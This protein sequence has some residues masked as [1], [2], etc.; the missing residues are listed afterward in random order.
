ML[1]LRLNIT[2]SNIL[3]SYENNGNTINKVFISN[4]APVLGIR[5][6]MFLGLPDPGPVPLVRSTAPDPSLFS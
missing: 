4:S 2:E 3:Q 1:E 6:R 5:I